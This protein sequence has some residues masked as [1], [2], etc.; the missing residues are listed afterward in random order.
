MGNLLGL[1]SFLLM[2]KR[3]NLQGIGAGLR[4]MPQNSRFRGE[5][6]IFAGIRRGSVQKLK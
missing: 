3:A 1:K 6:L 5:L 4:T 2:E